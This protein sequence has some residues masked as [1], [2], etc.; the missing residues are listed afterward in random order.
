MK[1]SKREKTSPEESDITYQFKGQYSRLQHWFNIDTEWIEY[2]FMKKE[3]NIF[4]WLYLKHIPGQ[5]NKYWFT[6][7]V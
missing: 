3:P 6:T 2:N 5:T 1:Q 4:K 7:L